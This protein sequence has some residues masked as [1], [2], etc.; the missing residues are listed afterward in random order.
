MKGVNFTKALA[1]AHQSE[2]NQM[3]LPL[4]VYLYKKICGDEELGISD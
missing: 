2:L 1:S 3:K 4:P